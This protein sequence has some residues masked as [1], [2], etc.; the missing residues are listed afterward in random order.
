[1]VTY[2]LT[3]AKGKNDHGAEDALWRTPGDPDANPFMAPLPDRE[4]G[5]R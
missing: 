4:P 2:D 3:S 1:M 5:G